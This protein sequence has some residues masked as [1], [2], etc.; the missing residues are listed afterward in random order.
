V[1]LIFPAERVNDLTV[2]L[3]AKYRVTALSNLAVVWE[4]NIVTANTIPA[5]TDSNVLGSLLLTNSQNIAQW[6]SK[7]YDKAARDNIAE[8]LKVFEQ[9]A[10]QQ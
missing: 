4:K 6:T 2:R 5:L 8:F 10:S 1:T 3:E 9:S 7:A